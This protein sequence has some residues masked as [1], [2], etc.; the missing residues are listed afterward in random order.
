[1]LRVD[2]GI[3]YT[4]GWRV[5]GRG[6]GT[7]G[8]LGDPLGLVGRRFQSEQRRRFARPTE[9][10]EVVEHAECV[11]KLPGACLDQDDDAIGKP[12]RQPPH[13][14]PTSSANRSTL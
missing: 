6:L 9:L 2:A 3:K 10:R 5:I 11:R 14:A 7:L 13:C 12:E 1:M 8:E 4:C